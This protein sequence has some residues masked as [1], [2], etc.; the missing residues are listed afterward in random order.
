MVRS[1]EESRRS[2]VRIPLGPFLDG[3]KASSGNEYALGPEERS[4]AGRRGES[5]SA[6]IPLDSWDIVL[7]I[8]SDLC[9]D[10][11]QQESPSA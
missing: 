6:K 5:T 11:P 8:L 1:C 3:D 9:Q 7:S 2:G 10:T 4:E